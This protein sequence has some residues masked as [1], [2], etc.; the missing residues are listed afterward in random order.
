[1]N[2]TVML[3]WGEVLHGAAWA[4]DSPSA[5]WHGTNCAASDSRY[6]PEQGSRAPQEPEIMM[7]YILIPFFFLAF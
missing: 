6:D 4:Q 1:M 2:V 5:G 7:Q 3:T